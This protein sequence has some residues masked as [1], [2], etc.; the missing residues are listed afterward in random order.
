MLNLTQQLLKLRRASKDLTMGDY[1]EHPTQEAVFAY[2]RGEGCLVGLNFSAETQTLT[3]PSDN[4]K[5][6]LT[7]YMDHPQQM[8]GASIQLRPNEGILLTLT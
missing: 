5:L 6:I 2:F 1:R 7:T 3:L 8:N 4:Y